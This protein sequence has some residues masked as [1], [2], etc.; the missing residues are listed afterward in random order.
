VVGA[1]GFFYA[2]FRRV[3]DHEVIEIFEIGASEAA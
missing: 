3:S 1:I 2:D